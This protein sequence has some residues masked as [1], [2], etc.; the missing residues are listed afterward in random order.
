VL[1]VL[2]RVGGF[3]VRSA[4]VLY[5]LAVVVV[6]VHAYRAA[7]QRGRSSEHVLPGV[8]V[9]VVAAFLGARL[10]GALNEA[11]LGAPF[12]MAA[13]GSLSFFGGLA[14]GAL[15]LLVY[16]RLAR[17]PVGMALDVLAPIAPVVYAIFRLGCLLN[18]DD[19]GPQTSM[20]WG[21]SF[22]RGTPP[23][24][25]PVHPTPLYELMAMAPVWFWLRSRDQAR[26][27]AGA[28]AFQL[29]VLLG[30]E[31]FVIDFWRPSW[32]RPPGLLL[33]QWYGLGLMLTGVA[34]IVWTR[35]AQRARQPPPV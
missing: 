9:V 28:I 21:M 23:T 22:P 30:L 16:L 15:A 11:A 1:P 20:P 3:E 7:R 8:T 29:C 26:L 24:L 12:T 34:G 5:L 27:P 31:R 19:Y 4:G 18:G 6:L 2:L 33:S 13:R 10:H 17:L 14:L 32:D 35:R 25:E